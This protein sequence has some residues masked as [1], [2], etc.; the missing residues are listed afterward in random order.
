MSFKRKSK[1]PA[2]GKARGEKFRKL[3]Y[4]VEGVYGR[5]NKAAIEKNLN[6][7]YSTA[8]SWLNGTCAPHDSQ[9]Y[10]DV[11]ITLTKLLDGVEEEQLE[12]PFEDPKPVYD[13]FVLLIGGMCGSVVTVAG[14]WVVE[15][16]L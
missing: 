16:L 3:F 11:I 12:L 8:R 5:L 1:V 13:P 2:G 15:N 7:S 9:Q 4:K 14:V 10:R 6:M